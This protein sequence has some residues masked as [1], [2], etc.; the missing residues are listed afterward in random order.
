MT[1]RRVRI[2]ACV[3]SGEGTMS[4][5][6]EHDPGT[7]SSGAAAGDREPSDLHGILYVSSAVRPLTE[8]EMERILES[9]RRRNRE[10]GVTG[11]LLHQHGN[12][13]QFI[14]G[15]RQGL[16]RVFEII[17]ESPYHRG[18]VEIMN[19]PTP[20][21]QFPEWSMAY[22]TRHVQAFTH[23]ELYDA[24]LKPGLDLESPGTPPVV[25]VLNSFWNPRL[26]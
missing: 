1:G 22:R 9:A 13:M 14:E 10:A 5:E 24:F 17:R 11:I 23:P 25:A 21:R 19:G 12:F 15:P 3:K 7:A 2:R 16:S 26:A 20:Q 6:S 4:G 8:A 18:I